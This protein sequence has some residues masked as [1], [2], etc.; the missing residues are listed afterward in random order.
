MPKSDNHIPKYCRH[1]GSGQAYVTLEGAA[2]YLG[3]Y[4]T[5]ES[6]EKYD[7]LIGEYLSSGRHMPVDP[8]SITI[9]EMVNAFREHAKTYYL[10]EG[11]LGKQAINIDEAL[12]PLLKLYG[13]TVAADFGPRRLK[14]VRASMIENGHVRT[15]INRLVG[16]IKHVF[17]WA[18]ENELIPRDVHYGLLAVSGLKAGKSGAIESQPVQRVPIECVEPVLLHVSPQVAAMIRLQLLTGMRP[19]EV[20]IMRGTDI[21]T[22]AKEWIYRPSRHKNQSRGQ[23]R[24]VPLGPKAKEIVSQFLKTDMTAYLFS[25]AEA[26]A[27]RRALLHAQRKTPLNEGNRPRNNRK[28]YPKRSPGAVYSVSA[29]YCAILRDGARRALQS[30]IERE[31]GMSPCAPSQRLFC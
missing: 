8:H 18:V 11:Q 28:R 25:P 20:C 22:T 23:E 6:R 12:R 2:R 5:A 26:E 3:I 29:Y 13:R 30:A 31:G 1:R 14:A 9:A 7:R 21:E 4:G 10:T 27:Q 16:R 15:Q 17:K 19:G 24:E